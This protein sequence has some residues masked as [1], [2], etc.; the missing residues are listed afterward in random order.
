MSVY[1]AGSPA[2]APAVTVRDQHR[3]GRGHSSAAPSWR[4]ALL[5]A[6]AHAGACIDPSGILA[7]QRLRHNGHQEQRRGRR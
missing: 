4:W 7:V 1:S 5:E 6:L 3:I 2:F